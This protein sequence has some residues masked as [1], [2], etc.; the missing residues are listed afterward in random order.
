MSDRFEAGDN[1]IGTTS[2]VLSDR[3]TLPD[4]GDVLE[5]TELLRIILDLTADTIVRFDRDLRYDYVN[6]RSAEAAGIA[7]ED[8][9]GHTQAELGYGTEEVALRE[10][11]IQKVLS[12]G[13]PATH[14]DEIHNALGRRWYESQLF[15]QYG[16]DGDVAHVVVVSR[17]ITK[18][19]L[20]ELELKWSARHD[21][22]T[23]LA[24]R[25]ALIEDLERSVGELAGEPTATAVLLIDL[26]HFKFVNDSLGH[27]VGDR[28][29]EAASRRIESCTRPG[30]LVARHGGDEFVV[31]LHDVEVGTDITDIA[32]RLAEAFRRPLRV[33]EHA[34]STTVSIGIATTDTLP[35]TSTS[36]HDLIR[37][38]D[39]AMFKAKNAGRD[40]TVVFDEALHQQVRERFEIANELSGAL[41]RGALEVWYQPEVD[42]A[43]GAPR[44]LEALLRWNRQN[45]ELTE[46]G[47]F[48]DVAVETGQITEIGSWAIERAIHDL[49]RWKANGVVMR[50]NLAPRQIADPGLL[51]LIDRALREHRLTPELL[52]F[53]IT[54]TALLR[55]N[56]VVR[57][58]LAGL[59]ER[60]HSVA[61]D[62][63]GTG[64]ASLSYLRLYPIDVIKVDRSFITDMTADNADHDLTAAIVAMGRR[65]GLEVTAEGIE[66]QSQVDLLLDMGCE[67]GQGYLFGKAQP[68]DRIDVILDDQTRNEPRTAM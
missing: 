6:D 63:F 32:E 13:E 58:N 64:Y 34:I 57:T 61:I 38:A 9:I 40:S 2:D 4:R 39:T 28:F 54:E 42:L 31:V 20:A 25:T 11:R 23:G 52:C 60:G 56:A 29:L 62:D 21:P 10:E 55:D 44:A 65:L 26:D 47:R 12:T 7:R 1:G 16:H 8:W 51:Q 45:G 15:P 17:D 27:V 33:E 46:A 3:D 59:A 48:I 18:R 35:T 68:R 53:E 66:H 24:N 37:E 30:D 22:L 14:V 43:S 19:K 41:S 36:P 50:I 49:T 67:N 5:Q